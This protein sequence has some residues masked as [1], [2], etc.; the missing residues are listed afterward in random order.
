VLDSKINWLPNNKWNVEG[1][2]KFWTGANVLN[3]QNIPVDM[4]NSF[5]LNATIQYKL[6]PKWSTWLKGE[7]LLD[8][9]YERWLDYPSLGVQLMGGVVYSFRK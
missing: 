3:Q 5:V 1:N 6:T 7:N 4:N 2:V 8:R 9:P